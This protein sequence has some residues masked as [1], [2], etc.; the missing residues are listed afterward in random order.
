VA[1][2]ALAVS[3]GAALTGACTA[4]TTTSSSSG[5]TS[6]GTGTTAPS[7]SGRTCTAA[8]LTGAVAGTSG[9]AG[10]IEVTLTL[11]NTSSSPCLLEG[12]PGAQMLAASGAQLPTTVVRGGGYSFTAFAPGP[13]TLAPGAVAYVNVGYSDVPS[14]GET[15]CPASTQLLVTPPNAY[16][17]LTVAAQLQPCAQGTLTV[18]PVFGSGSPDTQTTA[19]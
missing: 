5:T 15:S 11:R 12:Y 4:H 1:F 8:D 10:T 7:A 14:G 2:A 19:P 17:H 13:V 6:V 18:S 9:A 16:D 3:A